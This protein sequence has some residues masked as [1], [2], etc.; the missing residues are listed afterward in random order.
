MS[1]ACGTINVDNNTL[2]WV[3]NTLTNS[4]VAPK[5]MIKAP[6][7]A[8][9]LDGDVFAVVDDVITKAGTSEITQPTMLC[10][11]VQLDAAA[12]T[13]D[14]GVYSLA[15]DPVDDDDDDDEGDEGDENGDE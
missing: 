4:P 2:F 7:G 13:K 9:W 15:A 8:F 11:M 10:G 14:N 1:N 3:G 5:H 6:C 12:F